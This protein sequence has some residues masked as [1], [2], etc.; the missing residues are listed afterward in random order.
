M[1]PEE[2]RFKN[3]KH[4]EEEYKNDKYNN[5]PQYQSSFDYHGQYNGQNYSHNT[6]K[7]TK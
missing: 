3:N 7:D 2:V 6:K 5:Y 4:Y 1:R